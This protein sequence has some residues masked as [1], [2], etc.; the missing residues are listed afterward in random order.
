M[1]ITVKIYPESGIRRTDIN[2][3]WVYWERFINNS[4]DELCSSLQAMIPC[5][6][7]RR[8][9]ISVLSVA[10]STNFTNQLEHDRVHVLPIDHYC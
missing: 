4:K 6:Q 2:W 9:D 7:L 3:A 10:S 5:I 8:A 1:P